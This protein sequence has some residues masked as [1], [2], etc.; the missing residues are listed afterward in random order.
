M[1]KQVGQM[2]GKS[3]SEERSWKTHPALKFMYWQ[4]FCWDTENLPIGLV[5]SFSMEK[6]SKIS[7]STQYLFHQIGLDHLSPFSSDL[8][9][10]YDAPFPD[11][12][13]KMGPRAMPSQVP[14]IPDASL[15]AQRVA[16]EF[17]ATSNK[18]F[19]SVFAGN[20]PVTNGI[21]KDVLKMAPNAKS[22]PHIGGG[23]FYQWTKPEKL[24][25][26]LI[27]FIKEA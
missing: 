7:L 24:S 10:A 14:I 21:E 13:Y 4:K 22:A 2:D 6:R 23:H 12:S 16:R 26:I 25:Q 5:N 11:S 9:K 18:P 20:D 1:A 15:E 27:G 17:F 3:L 19:L 8:V